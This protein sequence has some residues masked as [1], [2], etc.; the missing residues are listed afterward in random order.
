MKQSTTIA[1]LCSEYPAISH[2][3]IFREIASLRS[4]GLTV[5]PATIRQSSNIGVMTPGE[6]Q[7]AKDTFVVLSRTLPSIF[8][9]HAHCMLKNPAG[10][11]RMAI[12]GL[13]P[14]FKGPSPIKAAAYFAEAE[15]SS[16]GFTTWASIMSMN[17][18]ATLLPLSL[19][20]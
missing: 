2:T 1:Y 5:H 17:I 18:S 12:A 10:Y 8:K 16:N 11:L 9:A 3:F 6:Q 7:E 13:K 14:V 15:F 19:S 20:L 4:A